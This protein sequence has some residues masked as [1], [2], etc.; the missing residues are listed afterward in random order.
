VI[1]RV[2]ELEEDGRW[3]IIDYKS[4]LGASAESWSGTRITEPQLPIYASLVFPEQAVGAVAL[5]RV[6]LD[7]AGFVGIAEE[8]GLLPS[9][10]GLEASRKL[11]AE[12]DFP[13]WDTLRHVWADSVR[14]IAGEIRDGIAA[15]V[16]ADEAQLAH[17]DVLPVLRLAERRTQWE[18]AR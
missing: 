4:G 2:D 5:A 1:D 9:V 11:Y 18:Q 8:D 6:T 10:K 14:T 3:V 13:D 17:C 12:A 16:V 15:V 7:G